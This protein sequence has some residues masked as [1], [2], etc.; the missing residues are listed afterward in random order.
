MSKLQQP[1]LILNE[2]DRLRAYLAECEKVL[3]TPLDANSAQALLRS[4]AEAHRL[5]TAL[6]AAGTDVRA[7]AAR[8]QTVTERMVK[9]AGR[10]V[11]AAGGERQFIAL[12]EQI[13]PG[14]DEPWWSLE[15]VVAAN[16]RRLMRQ[17]LA[18]LVIVAILGLAGFLL[19]DVLFPP[20]PVGDAVFAAQ[21][22]LQ[23]GDA[24]RALEALDQGLQASPDHPTLLAWKGTILEARGDPA[25]VGILEAAR[26]GLG[27]RDYLLE[28]SQVNLLLSRH[29]QVIA[30]MTYSIERFADPA[31]AY[32]MRATALEQQGNIPQAI[33]DLEA[34]AAIA[35][36]S[37]ND[38]L[39][40][41]VRVRLGML[42]QIAPGLLPTPAP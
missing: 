30:D 10:I 33:R 21:S 31:D 23:R 42:L 13:A 25:A 28:R 27:E 20:N 38:A 22:A 11:A 37:G 4:T 32:L 40:A 24:L 5:L 34:A 9:D 39:F 2:G 8:W 16:R 14:L 29:D 7:E 17:A 15:A 3:A 18:G 12:R 36:R 26:L 41:T 35:E 19:R 1:S 6:R